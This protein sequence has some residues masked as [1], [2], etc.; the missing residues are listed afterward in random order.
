MVVK[1]HEQRQKTDG[2][3]TKL[4]DPLSSI[5]VSFSQEIR[6]ILFAFIPS[7]CIKTP[8]VVTKQILCLDQLTYIGRYQLEP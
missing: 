7:S 3:N 2:R 6:R 8:V 1:T 4:L 5:A